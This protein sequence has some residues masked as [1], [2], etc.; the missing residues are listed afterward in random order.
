MA[1]DKQPGRKPDWNVT[2][3]DKVTGI[4]GPI[5]VGWTDPTDGSIKVKLNPFVVLDTRGNDS[6]IALWKNVP[7]QQPRKTPTPPA[8]DL[9]PQPDIPF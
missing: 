6:T 7:S 9:V 3:L 5:G 2:V 4:K 8:D 1:Q